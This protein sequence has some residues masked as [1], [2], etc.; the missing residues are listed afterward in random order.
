MMHRLLF[1]C[2]ACAW[3]L[4][5]Y[6]S[7]GG[8]NP[9]T[10]ILLDKGWSY[11][12]I[13][14]LNKN[15]KLTPVNIPHTWNAH[16]VKGTY[17]YNREMMVYRRSLE[18]TPDMEGKRLFLY[19]EGVNSVANVFVNKK[20]VG[21]HLGGYTA[22][23][24][25]I[26][27][28]VQSGS[29]SL[30]VWVS[31]AFRT[32]VLP[33]SGD[34][35]VYGGIHRPCYLIVTEKNCI[36]PLF[37]ASPGVFIHQHHVS[38]NVADITIESILS[39]KD[40]KPGLALK[41][42][43]TDADGRIIA[44]AETTVSE[45]SI[46]Q[47]FKIDKPNL[48]NGKKSPH[49][50]TVSVELC[51]NGK[52]ID[53]VEQQTGF[54]YFSVD[55]DK[56]FF[57]NGS[58]LNLYGFCQHEDVAGK[59]SA[60]AKEDYEKDIELIKESGATSLR[61]VHYPHAKPIYNLCDENG[62]V[63]W[64][65][66]PMCGPGGYDYAG[67]LRTD[68]FEDNARQVLKELVYQKYNHPSICFWGLFNE[69]RMD[70]DDA[71]PFVKELHALYK[72]LDP[73]RLTALASCVDKEYFNDCSDIVAWNKYYGWYGGSTAE[74]GPF[75]DEVKQG[76]KPV[77]V[78]EYGAGASIHH[79]Q[80]PLAKDNKANG[81]FHPEEWQN[82][83]HEGSWEAF[84][85]RPFMWGKYI[86][87][88]ADFQSTFR[89]EGDMDGINDKGLV[90][91]DRQTKKDAF[92][93]YKANWN[94]EPMLYISSRRFTE[95]TVANTQIKVYSNLD[96]ATLYINGKKISKQ[97]RDNLNRII[98]DNIILEPGQNAIRVEGKT[99]KG[100][101]NDSCMWTLK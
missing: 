32:D 26:T 63:I 51:E 87:V 90:T 37:H 14:N 21:T 101:V 86:W 46:K 18:V 100:G 15:S 73:S 8:E 1:F 57:L 30:D 80:W 33:I 43:L 96:E 74:A 66:I 93:F 89:T 39:L 3:V 88:F 61:L 40:I 44:S 42:K 68:A 67:Y 25:E 91:Y 20:T 34:F 60:L 11:K 50:Y 48:W 59:G 27:D 52:V 56:G 79:H 45:E 97:K 94:P 98:W 95:R 29:N 70:H 72:E 23:C 62:I 22:F 38:E 7:T 65:E 13:T 5:T 35:N 36:S 28:N 16:Y 49:L 53:K 31:N 84:V 64:T 75:F 55:T 12:P 78:S 69:V 81:K 83:Y 41:T 92:Y 54:R 85:E 71:E 17:S 4:A 58:Y 10:T 19:F 77:G 82:M 24:L 2:L 76:G 6:A 47:S 99:K 9:R